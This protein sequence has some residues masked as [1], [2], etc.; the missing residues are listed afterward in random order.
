[1]T[2]KAGLKPRSRIERLSLELAWRVYE[3]APS[4]ADALVH[5]GRRYL[6][7]LLRYS[8]PLMRVR[9]RTLADNEPGSMLVAGSCTALLHLQRQ[10]LVHDAEI[11]SLGNCPIHAL[12]RTLLALG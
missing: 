3:D 5:F 1:M 8:V 12:P 4:S 6:L 7:P 10:F 9:G 2:L 11:E